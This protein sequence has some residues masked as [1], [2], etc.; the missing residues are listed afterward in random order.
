MV[1]FESVRKVFPNG[2][3]G[4][5]DVTFAVDPGELVYIVGESGAGK[6]TLMRLLIRELEPT[7]GVIV[8]DGNEVTAL[9]RKQIPHLR[10][11]VGV[12]FQDYKLIPDR[13]VEENLELALE[14]LG[15]KQQQRAEAIAD[16]LDLVGLA[17]KEFLFPAQLSGGELQRVAIAR[18]LVV[19]PKVLFADEPTGN[20]DR[21]TARGIMALL[22]KIKTLGTTVLVATHDQ[23]I[24]DEHPA[25]RIRLQKGRVV[26]DTGVNRKD[27]PVEPAAE[28][29][30]ESSVAEE[31]MEPE[32]EH[33]QKHHRHSKKK[34][35][36]A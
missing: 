25:R 1:S 14:I 23:G 36:V 3:V 11:Q 4:L 18:S 20:L 7:E 21:E 32:K 22:H 17:D 24:M 15:T 35:E 8:V 27:E 31:N 12:V 33:K 29:Q 28:V 2:Y 19:A 10:R 13:T 30:V 16:V 9:P 26:E 5:E 6:T 34:E